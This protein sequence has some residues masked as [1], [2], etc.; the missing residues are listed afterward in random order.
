MQTARAGVV[1]THSFRQI[2][3]EIIP[4]LLLNFLRSGHRHYFKSYISSV[5]V[6]NAAVVL[7]YNKTTKQLQDLLSINSSTIKP[8]ISFHFKLDSIKVWT[9]TLKVKW[10]FRQVI[11]VNGLSFI[12]PTMATKAGII[13]IFLKEPLIAGTADKHIV[14]AVVAVVVIIPPASIR[15]LTTI[16]TMFAWKSRRMPRCQ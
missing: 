12:F 4:L 3:K 8:F 11:L 1:R 15:L 2:I 7:D 6:N 13:V 16:T 14:V 5:L 10:S 9:F